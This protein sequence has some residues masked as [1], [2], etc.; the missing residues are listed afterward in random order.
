MRL[1]VSEIIGVPG[2]RIPFEFEMDLSNLELHYQYPVVKP[3]KVKGFVENS[4]GVLKVKARLETVLSLVCDRC[5][6][7][8]T[9]EKQLDVDAVLADKPQDRQNEEFFTLDGDW[10]DIG[11][12]AVSAL[13][14]DMDMKVLCREDCKGLCPLCGKNLNEGECSCPAC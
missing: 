13:I 12:I 1:N 2:G 10:A 7:I 11:E 9:R 14:L 4:A 3:L 6:T 5:A 8:F